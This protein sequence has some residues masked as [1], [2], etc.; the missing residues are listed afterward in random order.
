MYSE[1]A[2]FDGEAGILPE[3]TSKYIASPRALSST[4]PRATAPD[5]VGKPTTKATVPAVAR[6]VRLRAQ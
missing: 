5:P 3:L 6:K 2:L 4:R 1:D